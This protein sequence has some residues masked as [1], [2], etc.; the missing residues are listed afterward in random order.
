MRQMLGDIEAEVAHT[1]ELTGVDALDDLVL[2]A[3]AQAPRDEFVSADIKPWAFENRPL[4]IASGQ[5]ISQPYIVALM[6]ELLALA[7]DHT[8]LEIGT[9]SGYQ[10]AV[11]SRLCRKVYSMDLLP[12]LT[13][14]AIARL[15][16]LGFDNIQI[17][18]GDG[19][20]GWPQYAP[21]DGIIGGF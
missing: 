21:Y 18:S 13:D 6:T 4:P 8:V 7:P 12:A 1:R 3:I 5:T 9:G 15:A 17:R 14:S 20:E 11:L 10:T 2:E 19:H 16:L